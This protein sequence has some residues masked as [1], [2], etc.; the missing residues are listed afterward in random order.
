MKAFT[1]IELLL[2]ITVIAVLIAILY[3]ALYQVRES[4][5]LTY[6]SINMKQLTEVTTLYID[7]YKVLPLS[8]EDPLRTWNGSIPPLEWEVPKSVF[9]CPSLQSKYPGITFKYRPGRM[10]TRN[11]TLA[12]PDYTLLLP[13]TKLYEIVPINWLW[14]DPYPVH[15]NKYSGIRMNERWELSKNYHLLDVINP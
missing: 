4:A 8:I 15:F 2:S 12:E 14:L 13:T 1:L 5:R 7:Q 3:P 10:L 6:C 11:A 9:T